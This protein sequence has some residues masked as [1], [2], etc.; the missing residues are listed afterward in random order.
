MATVAGFGC[1]F[2]QSGKSWLFR[3]MLQ[4]YQD[5]WVTLERGRDR[6]ASYTNLPSGEYTFKVLAANSDGVWNET[7]A[8][9][10]NG[11]R[12]RRSTS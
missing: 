10:R 3:Y 6:V 5:E 7:G 11:D 12:T 1:K 9:G 4:G 2:G 8:T